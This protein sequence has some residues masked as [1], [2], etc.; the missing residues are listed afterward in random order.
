MNSLEP[1]IFYDDFL[2]PRTYETRKCSIEP[3]TRTPGS[4]AFNLFVIIAGASAASP[5]LGGP[6]C[7][8][9]WGQNIVDTLW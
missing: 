6:C 7:R 5:Q 8:E 3:G 1:G 4:A 9:V 2:Y